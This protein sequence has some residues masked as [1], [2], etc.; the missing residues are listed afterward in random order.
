DLAPTRHEA[1]P[2]LWKFCTSAE[3]YQ[4]RLKEFAHQDKLKNS[5]VMNLS[6]GKMIYTKFG[7]VNFNLNVNNLLNNRNIMTG[8]FQESKLDYTNY[9]LT[10]FPNRYYYAQGIRIFFNVGIRF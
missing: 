5:F 9:S 10:K 4:E 1:L 2:G 6:I 3:E 7:G 8:G